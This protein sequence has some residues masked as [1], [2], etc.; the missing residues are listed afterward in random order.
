MTRSVGTAATTD[1]IARAFVAACLAE[2]D[3]PKPGN[4]HR[5]A[6][7]HGMSVDDFVRSAEAAAPAIAT[8]GATVGRRVLGAVEATRTAAGQNTNL[9]IVLLCAPLAVAA[10]AAAD[11][12]LWPALEA[13]LAGLTAEDAGL[14]YRAIR[15][16]SPG[17]LGRSDA[18]DVA[19]EPS[20]TLLD[21]M[22]LAAGRDRIAWNYANGLADVRGF[23]APR[24]EALL[25]AGWPE[26]WAV[27]GTYL[28]FLGH[29]PDT[30][31]VRKRGIAAAEAVRTRAAQVDAA[32]LAA[33][34]P[35]S[36]LPEIL[37]FDA[38]LKAAGLNPGTSADLTVATA[39]ARGLAATAAAG[40][41]SRRLPDARLTL[42]P[43]GGA[44]VPALEEG[45]K[46][47]R[48]STR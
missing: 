27:A 15:L 42:Y 1:R 39:F 37:A 34:E 25:G 23:G 22:R 21:A 38:E 5:H 10:E 47:W 9:G 48:K 13:V 24:L 26:P 14:A 8:P 32:L 12:E 7:G 40:P 43:H 28:A 18:A 45:G 44:A 29:I 20:V 33:A 16:A 2:L 17:G 6:A 3:A 35:A 41:G 30:H 46:Q 36:L 19:D 4:V 31:I 11:G